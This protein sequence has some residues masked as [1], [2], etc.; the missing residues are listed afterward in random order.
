MARKK[1]KI[2]LKEAAQKAAL[3]SIDSRVNTD[4]AKKKGNGNSKS[5]KK[6]T[7]EIKKQQATA[8]KKMYGKSLSNTLTK[9]NLSMSDASKVAA[10]NSIDNRLTTDKA[11]TKEP[12]KATGVGL[13]VA[14]GMQQKMAGHTRTAKNLEKGFTKNQNRLEIENAYK[15]GAI[16]K[17]DYEKYIKQNENY[18]GSKFLNDV[19]N[20]SLQ[21]GQKLQEGIEE[22]G[23]GD[24]ASRAIST[25]TQLATDVAVMLT[26][27]GK[28]RMGKKLVDAAIDSKAGQKL[29]NNKAGKKALDFAGE[30]LDTAMTPQQAE[31]FSQSYGLYYDQALAEGAT[32]EQAEEAAIKK[33]LTDVGI[34]STGGTERFISKW[35]KPVAKSNIK[36]KAKDFTEGALTGIAEEVG[37][38]VAGNVIDRNVGFG[39][40]QIINPEELKETAFISGLFG[41]LGGGVVGTVRRGGNTQNQ[42]TTEKIDKQREPEQGENNE[43]NANASE[44]QES[45]FKTA[46]EPLNANEPNLGE[47][48]Y[49]FDEVLTLL[50][51][52]ELSKAEKERIFSNYIN[53]QTENQA[54]SQPAQQ[55]AEQTPQNEPVSTQQ[56]AEQNNMASV[57]NEPGRAET[58]YESDIDVPT[59]SMGEM[60]ND[61]HPVYTDEE[62]IKNARAKLDSL[63]PERKNMS[64]KDKIKLGSLKD[65]VIEMAVQMSD[66]AKI[67]ED[68]NASIMEKQKARVDMEGIYEKYKDRLSDIAQGLQAGR[69]IL[70]LINPELRTMLTQK[71]ASNEIQKRRGYNPLELSNKIEDKITNETKQ[72]ATKEAI[73]ELDE[74]LGNTEQIGSPTNKIEFKPA[75]DV[76]EIQALAEKQIR[77]LDSRIKKA[78]DIKQGR[79]RDKETD[80][81]VNAL[82]VVQKRALG[83]LKPNYALDADIQTEKEIINLITTVRREFWGNDFYDAAREKIIDKVGEKYRQ[84]IDEY[85]KHHVPKFTEKEFN[86]AFS[87]IKIKYGLNFKDIVAKTNSVALSQ[88]KVNKLYQEEIL[89]DRFDLLPDEKAEIVEKI[90]SYVNKKYIDAKQNIL[91][92]LT[93]KNEKRNKDYSRKIKQFGKYIKAGALEHTDT[94]NALKEKMQPKK[95]G[96]KPVTEQAK[97]AINATEQVVA[98]FI[99][100]KNFLRECFAGDDFALKEID[101]IFDDS[102]V[103]PFTQKLGERILSDYCKQ[104]DTTLSQLLI[105]NSFYPKP[106]ITKTL[107]QHIEANQGRPLTQVERI[108]IQDT[109][110]GTVEN[111]I[112]QARQREI[113]KLM[114]KTG[115]NGQVI[116]NKHRSKFLNNLMKYYSLDVFDSEAREKALQSLNLPL[117]SD[118]D[119]AQITLYA[120][121]QQQYNWWDREYKILNAKIKKIA[122]KYS[123]PTISESISAWNR[124]AMLSSPATHIV[125]IDGNIVTAVVDS[126]LT[127]PFSTFGDYIV[128]KTLTNQRSIGLSNPITRTK[129]AIQGIS[130]T[131]EEIKAGLDVDEFSK[132]EKQDLAGDGF[133]YRTNPWKTDKSL[134][135]KIIETPMLAGNVI[136]RGLQGVVNTGLKFGDNPFKEG[137]RQGEI[138]SLRKLQ[139]NGESITEE[140]IQELAQQASLENTFQDKSEWASTL[141][142]VRSCFN[143]ITPKLRFGDY[144]IT[145]ARTPANIAKMIYEYSLLGGISMAKDYRAIKKK[146]KT[147]ETVTRMEQRQFVDKFGKFSAGVL[148]RFVCG[149]LLEL[150]LIEL[151]GSDVGEPGSDDDEITES[152]IGEQPYSIRIKKPNGEYTY[153]S[154]AKLQPVSSVIAGSI[155]RKDAA[156]NALKEAGYENKKELFRVAINDFENF[157][158]AMDILKKSVKA[159]CAAGIATFGEN[160][161]VSNFTNLIEQGMAY[162]SDKKVLPAFFGSLGSSYLPNMAGRAVPSVWKDGVE[163]FDGVKR[164]IYENEASVQTMINTLKAR[165]GIGR[166]N[167]PIKYN[168]LGEE[169][170]NAAGDTDLQRVINTWFNPLQTTKSN[171]DAVKQELAKNGVLPKTAPYKVTYTSDLGKEEKIEMTSAERSE[172]NRFVGGQTQEAISELLNSSAYRDLPEENQVDINKKISQYYRNLYQEELLTEKG[173]VFEPNE[174][175]IRVQ[176]AEANG[177]TPAEYYT[178]KSQR[179]V[180][181]KKYEGQV[182]SSVAERAE[183]IKFVKGQ[184]YGSENATWY[185]IKKGCGFDDD[186]KI[187]K[188]YEGAIDTGF[189]PLTYANVY[190]TSNSFNAKNETG[191]SVTGLKKKRVVS[192]L[193]SCNLTAEQKY[194]ILDLVGLS[195]KNVS[196]SDGGS[197][198]VGKVNIPK[199]GG[200]IDDT[201]RNMANSANKTSSSSSNS[202]SGYKKKSYSSKSYSAPASS[203]GGYSSKNS[204]YSGSGYSGYGGSGYSGYNGTGY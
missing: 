164:D 185:A 52:N 41:G 126:V 59:Q 159:G 119:L 143:K 66:L 99:D 201:V 106:N 141:E 139:E 61:T 134:K 47:N 107:L 118:S 3:N 177:L 197:R 64:D 190:N 62:A 191:Q 165:T 50:S 181:T 170:P 104:N 153:I 81:F 37:L 1:N 39:S 4:K 149:K 72:T 168:E 138:E 8:F 90:S 194:Y 2:T 92:E 31:R 122:N 147:G 95:T 204:G 71:K 173:K 56:Q 94:K 93:Q 96:M 11:N 23:L 18:Q 9:K 28:G 187:C 103:M 152:L 132:L 196:F 199:A 13:S 112:N 21:E 115:D 70:N 33:A 10:I 43:L 100:M 116:K 54:T 156:R 192:Y 53:R 186:D 88:S 198:D 36:Q 146:L 80:V 155:D 69:V 108:A 200:T 42:P 128:S 68:P 137:Y 167:L 12:N 123:D 176:E 202:S 154:Y 14:L 78:K 75:E 97:E 51:G 114:K 110:E 20:V 63:I 67:V 111:K 34:E 73:A 17:K 113:E 162:R 158:E 195:S 175:V 189:D 161:F 142:S 25:G 45:Q 87:S 131:V 46:T 136:A 60:T 180:I 48:E 145:F 125:N 19:H 105:E 184:D 183:F 203:S 109:I 32:E 79:L 7:E 40:D 174:E 44:T 65:D 27:A 30:T 151:T 135:R 121:E 86:K 182:D 140:E 5:K 49:N 102:I 57:Q 144:L 82:N 169:V 163:Y 150:G 76:A 124:A 148:L 74:K 193:N 172:F 160:S 171:D 133:K 101:I 26:P 120:R 188:Y 91:K 129:G 117:I 166:K 29:V 15:Q 58:T 84:E 24:R 35:L 89:Q 6:T 55:Q 22:S 179:Q 77:M 130:D 85:F 157:D 127:N 178:F 16:S 38:E 83:Y 98:D